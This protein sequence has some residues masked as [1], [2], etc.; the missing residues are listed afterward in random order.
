MCMTK[1]KRKAR[2]I[3]MFKEFMYYINVGTLYID[4]T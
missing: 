2:F 3:L 1:I 4:G